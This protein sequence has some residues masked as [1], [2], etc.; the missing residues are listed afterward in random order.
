MADTKSTRIIYKSALAVFK[1]KKV[2]MVRDFTRPDVFLTLGGTVEDGETDIDCLHREV[3][4]EVGVGV[5]DGSLKFLEQFEAP[6]HGKSGAR[7]NIRL[8]KGELA[9]E[10]VPSSEIVELQYFDSSIEDRYIN[11]NLVAQ[12]IFVWLQQNN[13]IG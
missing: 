4:E 6:A 8:F 5:K 7:V 9:G 1:D 13:Y 12:Q 2:L 11:G 3:K 10:P